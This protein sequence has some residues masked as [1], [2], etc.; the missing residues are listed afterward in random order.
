[1]VMVNYL[2]EKTLGKEC[3]EATDNLSKEWESVIIEN[4]DYCI[5]THFKDFKNIYVC[6]AVMDQE[7]NT[8]KMHNMAIVLATLNSE[9]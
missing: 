7:D 9:G 1:M 2:V 6:K 4:G 3:N 8:Y 5:I